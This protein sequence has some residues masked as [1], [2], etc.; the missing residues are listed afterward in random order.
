MEQRHVSIHLSNQQAQQLKQT[1]RL[2]MSPQMQ[3]AIQLLQVPIM[4]LSQII[5]T[6]MEHNP[7]LEYSHEEDADSDLHLSQ[8]EDSIAEIPEQN[9]LQPDR[10][11]VID[12]H[13]FELLKRLDEDFDNHFKESENYQSQSKVDD[14]KLKTYIENTLQ[15]EKSLFEHLMEQ[16]KTTFSSKEELIAA[17]EL[18]GNI[19]RKGFISNSLQEIACLSNIQTSLLKKILEEIQ[20]FDP[21]GIA[22]KNL[23][24]SLLIQLKMKN[25]E[26]TLAYKIVHQCYDDLIHNRFG[27]IKRIL[28]CT[29]A[30]INQSIEQEI[31]RLDVNPGAAYSKEHPQQIVPDVS[32]IQE[33]EGLVVSVNDEWI[34]QVKLNSKYLKMLN[35]PSL[36]QETHDFIKHKIQSAKWLIKN[37]FQRNG[38]LE[39]IGQHLAKYQR[40]FFIDPHGTLEPM[41]MKTVAEEL[42]LHESTIARAVANKYLYCDRGLFPLRHFFSHG[43][44]NAEGD[45]VS[46]KTVKHLLQ[47]LIDSEDRQHPHSDEILSKLMKERG[48]SCA[49]RTIAKYRAEM[50]I[51]NAQQRKKYE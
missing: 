9:E 8:L 35:N 49:R 37:I 20:T 36:N 34:P 38:T 43:Y 7:L 33:D 15:T 22:A 16:A 18:I 1:Q 11:I 32:I 6:E 51:G 40:N 48:I 31:S 39:R 17:E 29:A 4:E 19:D 45:D 5:A 14:E 50:V 26:S 28:R 47:E 3:Q 23:Q 10:E 27:N 13:D 42:E 41:T 44:V 25:K 24:E 46:S 30:E 2:I 12:E 21:P